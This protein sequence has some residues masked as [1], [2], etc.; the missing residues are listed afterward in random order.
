MKQKLFRWI[1]VLSILY[2]S[3]SVVYAENMNLI[4]DGKSHTYSGNPIHLYIDGQEI[5]TTVM[6]P[7]QLNNSILVPAKEVFATMGAEVE[8]RPSEQS[9]Y[10]HNEDILIVLTMNS[11]EAWVN[12]ETKQL[13]TP[14][15]LINDKVMIPL[16]FISESLGYTVTWSQSDYSVYIL[17]PE[18]TT[19]DSSN[20]SVDANDVFNSGDVVQET[21]NE[22][23]NEVTD[24][25]QMIE[26]ENSM[27]IENVPDIIFHHD[28][29]EYNDLSSTLTLNGIMGIS[30][31][32]VTY[33]ENVHEKQIII[34]LNEDYSSYLPPGS[35]T[36]GGSRTKQ[37]DIMQYNG[38]TRLIL[39]TATISALMV[40]EQN[41]QV[42]LQVVK[43]SEKYEKIVVLD[44]GHGAHDAGTSYGGIKEKDINLT[45]SNELRSL[46]EADPTI[47]VYATRDD[48]TF[49]E[50]MERVAFSNE[51][52]PDLFISMHVNSVAGNTSASGT[53]TYYTVDPDT[54][55]KTFATMVQEAL[56]KEFGTRNRGVKSNTFI[57]TRYTDA[58][59]IL[60]EIGFLTND[61]DRTMMTSSGFEKRYAQTV[62]QCI[63]NYY[64]QGLNN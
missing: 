40:G 59:A 18:K 46:L 5:L 33:E 37:M 9:V 43:P 3:C 17:T 35:F 36:I 14:A 42:S 7:I 51:I 32:Q 21:E 50:L 28:Y 48:D 1:M 57:V 25:E 29:I 24:E 64:A 12:G 8:W 55:N 6:P 19:E 56:V 52:E 10:I 60:I 23:E 62:Y 13:N 63:L 41:G 49:L 30:A 47:K 45:V 31:P 27:G 4:Y 15:K 39:T 11:Y 16:R 20:E 2:V 34:D 54:R 44:A 58:P 26:I 53:E 61:S 22:T 38:Q